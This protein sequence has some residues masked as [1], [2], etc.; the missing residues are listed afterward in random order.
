MRMTHGGCLA[1]FPDRVYAPKAHQCQRNPLKLQ[2]LEARK[3]DIMQAVK[4]ERLAFSGGV[5]DF[6]PFTVYDR[7]K[8]YPGATFPGPAIIEERESTII[9]GEGADDE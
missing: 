2:K 5:K 9:V 1:H 8:L 6:I 4:G 7:Y 3:G